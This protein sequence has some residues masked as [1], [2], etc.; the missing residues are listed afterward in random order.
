MRTLLTAALLLSA[1]FIHAQNWIVGAPVNFHLSDLQCIAYPPGCYP[2]PDTRFSFPMSNVSGVQHAAVV[3]GVSVT[4]CHVLPGPVGPLALLDTIWINTP[5]PREVIF[6][7]GSGSLALRFI[8]VG[9]PT[10]DGQ[11]HPCAYNNLWLGFG[12]CPAQNMLNLSTPCTV[13]PG[14]VGIQESRSTDGIFQLPSLA[15]GQLLTCTGA[16]ALEVFTISGERIAQRMG[17][18]LSLSDLNKG[19]YLARAQMQDGRSLTTRFVLVH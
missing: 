16:T 10:T 3:D 4:N 14:S 1:Q 17:T 8:A 18:A 9:T 19:V 6:P 12:L 11:P 5:D 7:S 13:Q 2:M 15:N